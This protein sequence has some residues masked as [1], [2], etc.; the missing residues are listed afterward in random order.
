[1]TERDG[2][3]VLRTEHLGR[4]VKG[5]VLVEDVSIEVPRGDVLAIVGPSGSG[6]SSFLRMLNRLDEPTRGDVYLDGQNTREMSPRRLRQRVGMVM[7]S[8]NLFPGTVADNLRYGP[9]QRGETVTDEA[10]EALLEQV[11]LGGYGSRDINHLSGGEAQRVSLARTLANKPDVLLLDE[12]TSALDDAAEEE[13]EAL[14]CRVMDHEHL[15]CLMVTHDMD[16]AARMAN[17]VMMMKEGRLA[18]M[19]RTEEILDADS[20]L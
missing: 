11:G 12:P 20:T 10:L 1:M 3:P 2:E 9:A 15:T 14:L 16:Q 7:Q 8:A 6:K 19:G 17:R 5:H 4:T 13:V 18:A